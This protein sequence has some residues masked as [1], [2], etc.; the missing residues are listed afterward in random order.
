MGANVRKSQGKIL[1]E[2]EKDRECERN[3][4]ENV[5]V[6]AEKCESARE[7]ESA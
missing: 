2:R 7:Q 4:G 6:K 5:C 1:R 3:V